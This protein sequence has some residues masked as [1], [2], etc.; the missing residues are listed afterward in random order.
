MS[1]MVLWAAVTR[2]TPFFSSS[3]FMEQKLG[4]IILS[5]RTTKSWVSSMDRKRIIELWEYYHLLGPKIGLDDR[6]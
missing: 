4:V 5:F 1:M 3:I 6:N 2:V